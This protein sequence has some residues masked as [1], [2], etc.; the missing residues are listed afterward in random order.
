MALLLDRLLELVP[1]PSVRVHDERSGDDDDEDEKSMRGDGFVG[2]RFSMAAVTVG[3]DSY[4][5][6]TCMG[7]IT[8]GHVTAGDTVT[9]LRRATNEDDEE[10]AAA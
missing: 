3:Y 5:G 8:S 4:L 10:A 2:D 9:F 7:R 6:R 1:E